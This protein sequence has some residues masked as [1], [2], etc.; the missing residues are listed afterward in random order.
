MKQNIRLLIAYD[1]TSF[2]GWQKTNAGPSVEGTLQSVLEQILQEKVALQAASRT[3]RGVH[4]EG[5]VV[6][7]LTEK[8]IPSKRSLNQLL[9]PSIR[10]LDLQEAS[11]TFHPTLDAK[12]KLYSYALCMG[13]SQAPFFRHFS[14]HVPD[15]L[16]L[17]DMQKA[18]HYL[19]GE[20]DFTSFCNFRENITYSDK[21]RR[22]E[23]IDFIPLENNRL[24][25]AIRGNHFLYKMVRNLV[26]T[27]VTVG[28]G[29][30]E[31]ER[32]PEILA[33]KHRPQAGVTAPAHGLTLKEIYFQT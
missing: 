15:L 27:L 24:L 19:I 16:K 32:I 28:R 12:G 10:V 1:G 8:S 26:G 5:Q 21:I 31:P 13:E 30:M 4:A 20:H 3:D 6:N 22:V 18:S 14:W 25:I 11:P 23:N 7:F 33:A 2:F 29:K 9:P 17:Q